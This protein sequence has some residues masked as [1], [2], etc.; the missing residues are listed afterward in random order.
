MINEE[1]TQNFDLSDN[2]C[3]LII[4]YLTLEERFRLERTS[5][6]FQTLI[7]KCTKNL[8]FAY[9]RRHFDDNVIRFEDDINRLEIVVKKTSQIRRIDMRRVR[10]NDQILDVIAANCPSLESLALY[11]HNVSEEC[12]RRFGPIMGTNLK[13]ISLQSYRDF[14]VC[15]RILNFTPNLQYLECDEILSF[16]MDFE[17][18]LPQLKALSISKS[19]FVDK[20]VEVFQRLVDGYSNRLLESL[21][22][23][24]YHYNQCFE[25][26]LTNI[27]RLLDLKELHIWFTPTVVDPTN[28]PNFLPQWFTT[29]GLQCNRLKKFICKQN[30]SRIGTDFEILMD[31]WRT[32]ANFKELQVLEL[33]NYF[34]LIDDEVIGSLN[35][36]RK[37]VLD[38]K[39]V[40]KTFFLDITQFAPNLKIFLLDCMDTNIRETINNS[41]I[42]LSK[43]VKL[44]EISIA[45]SRD[46]NEV[47][48]L[49]YDMLL[50]DISIAHLLDECHNLTN[51]R[52]GLSFHTFRPFPFRYL[53]TRNC[54]PKKTL[55][56]IG[57]VPNS[58]L[59]EVMTEL[60]LDVEIK[61]LEINR[62]DDFV[63]Y[64]SENEITIECNEWMEV[65][66]NWIL[67]MNFDNRINFWNFFRRL[68]DIQE[69]YIC[70]SDFFDDS[71]IK[72]RSLEKLTD[73]TIICDFIGF[74]FFTN[75][76]HLA[77]NI[78]KFE[79]KTRIR[80]KE[81][82]MKAFHRLKRLS[83]LKL[84]PIDD[85]IRS[86]HQ[87]SDSAINQLLDNCLDLKE[88]VFNFV[89]D[90]N[91]SVIDK[92]KA[93]ANKR[94]KEM[95]R[96]EY[97]VDKEIDS[98]L[99][100]DLPKNLFVQI[101]Q[102]IF[103][104]TE[105]E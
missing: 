92:L 52:F 70:V 73:V 102:R 101:R 82:S 42:A 100:S 61:R 80:L 19:R 84:I 13:S 94:P 41:L 33:K 58:C 26:M 46:P 22:L 18:D 75:I 76:T 72:I 87:L 2:I 90:I 67:R 85:F 99:L 86:R 3:E 103:V 40:G 57:Y 105:N 6:Q 8:I 83:V 21:T 25:R 17:H 98:N 95:I 30:V 43:C 78:E 37:L 63:D 16:D 1:M 54:R 74:G 91:R 29:V 4:T 24:V 47:K 36:L 59:S 38:I 64:E 7:N 45:L 62:S 69:L 55:V 49:T 5:K 53:N 93:M 51:I 20:D 14:S 15:H 56:F 81:H 50:D 79:L 39:S 89:L 96:F 32:F 104:N 88:I 28:P 60:A 35:K 9:N 11:L 27:Y 48:P 44:T 31:L 97:S 23:D 66:V 68:D 65:S 77:P 10:V 34:V 71:F 12:I